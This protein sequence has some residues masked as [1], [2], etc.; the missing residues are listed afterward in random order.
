MTKLDEIVVG[1]VEL[2]G[3]ELVG[4]IRL[5]KIVYLLEQVGMNSGVQ[6]V[7]HHYGPY[8][9][10]VSD[11]VADAKFWDHLQEA[12]EFRRI[13]GAPFS[14]FRATSDASK[15]QKLGGI[16]ASRARELLARFN[17]ESSTVL[18][19]AATIHWL[20]YV[21]KVADWRGE[22]ERRKPSKGKYGRFDKAMALLCDLNLMPN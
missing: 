21:E 17:Y 19:L 4:R 18:E 16:A 15:L 6:F 20:A 22:L 1:V 2:S 5:Q 7:Y 14:I 8:S 13:D 11:A 12:I 10:A 9:E 3:G